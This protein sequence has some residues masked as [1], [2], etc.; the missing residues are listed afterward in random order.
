MI[1]RY[2]SFY[3]RGA[4]AIGVG[5]GALAPGFVPKRETIR[6]MSSSLFTRGMRF[7]TRGSPFKESNGCSCQT[8]PVSVSS[9]YVSRSVNGLITIWYRPWDCR[10]GE[11][12]FGSSWAPTGSTSI[13]KIAAIMKPRVS[14]IPL[15]LV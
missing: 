2:K 9:K 12:V 5:R 8:V 14:I 15:S 1:K 3:W 10:A 4:G 11:A 6:A 13:D 7:Q